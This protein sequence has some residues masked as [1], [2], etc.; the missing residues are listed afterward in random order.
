[1][2]TR[3]AFLGLGT[4]GSRQAAVLAGAGTELTVYNRTFER[5]RAWGEE[6]GVRV[7]TSPADAARGAEVV[8]TMVV[9][10]PQVE[11]LLLG[12]DGAAATAAPRAL[13]VDMSTIAPEDARHI[14]AR[15]RE[16]DFAF[17]D[18]PVTGSAAKA[19]DGTL[20]IMVGGEAA[21]VERARPLL[22]VM[23]ERVLHVG[24]LGHGQTI[25]L[26]HNA[27][28]AINLATVAQA[29]V[30]G[31][32]TGVDRDALIS[33]LRAGAA[34]STILERKGDAMVD[35]DFTPLFKL[36][37]MLKDLR[38]CLDEAAAATVPFPLAGA[39]ADLYTAASASG[40]GEQDFAA[41]VHVIESL[42]GTRI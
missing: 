5:A 12:A 20:T 22:A 28:T 40:H 31:S 23:G 41:V 37:H 3:V 4:M 35:R 36:D 14:G 34:G 26:I 30:V 25:K 29:L 11:S 6:H 15:L 13:F 39:A 1:M 19:A 38:Y 33:V 17:V 42:A 16:R 27:V 9:D 32:R 2:S 8:I 10:G 7:A 24:P 21:D 18:A